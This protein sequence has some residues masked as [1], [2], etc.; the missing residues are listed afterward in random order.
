MGKLSHPKRLGLFIFYDRDGIVDD[1]VEYLLQDISENFT[2][3]VILSN[4]TLEVSEQKKL[5]KYSSD[6]IIREN[7][8][9]DQC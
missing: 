3:L 1:Y 6:I 4:S 5:E 8:G 7:K 9:L 2:R